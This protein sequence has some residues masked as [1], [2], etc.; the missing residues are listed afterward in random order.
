[1]KNKLILILGFFSLIGCKNINDSIAKFVFDSSKMSTLVEYNYKYD[2][3]KLISKTEMFYTYMYKQV[4][5]S[6]LIRTDY[7]YNDKGLLIKE[8]SRTNF[9]DSSS[10]YLYNY[11][12]NDSLIQEM[13]IN[14]NGDTTIWNEYAYFPDGKKIIFHRSI[15][16]H[17][18]P[19][20]D[21]KTAM[22]NPKMDTSFYRNEYDFKNNVCISER[23]YNQKGELTKTINFEYENNKLL[24]EKIR[25]YDY[26]K[27]EITPNYF[28][29]DSK[30]N[31]LEFCI[32]TF[33]SN[34]LIKK[35]NMYDYGKVYNEEYY[36]NGLLIGT[37]DYERQFTMNKVI[38]SYEYNEDG[39]L[40]TEKSYREKINAH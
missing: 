12:S 9:E 21:F 8:T 5:D 29:I 6:M 19:N 37:I 23:Q 40:K 18:D 36:K 14:E 17:F 31:T 16:K 34:K 38:Y 20:Q 28:S 25:Y 32:N 35:A 39:L 26:S 10:L 11:D 4:L 7:L 33:E 30:N 15:M 27:S 13:S 24:I 2:S 1:M 22:E 3:D